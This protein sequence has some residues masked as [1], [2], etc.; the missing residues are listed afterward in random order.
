M[1]NNGGW[2]YT[3]QGRAYYV[4]SKG[5]YL[6]VDEM[7]SSP[8]M[9]PILP[10]INPAVTGQNHQP[11][12]QGPCSWPGAAVPGYAHQKASSFIAPHFGN[13]SQQSS[14]AYVDHPAEDHDAFRD[15]KAEWG[16]AGPPD[17]EYEEEYRQYKS[18]EPEANKA[19]DAYTT[20]RREAS[21]YTGQEVEDNSDT[22]G[23]TPLGTQEFHR[24]AAVLAYNAAQECQRIAHLRSE[25]NKDYIGYHQP[26]YLDGHRQASENYERRASTF[27]ML[28]NAHGNFQSLASHI[29]QGKAR[30]ALR[31]VLKD[32]GN[33]PLLPG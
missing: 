29:A 17:S 13:G 32:A 24:E 31:A 18:A 4:D 5:H 25:Y 2:R 30:K 20:Y 1:D 33:G 8:D 6:Y 21:R 15:A 10:N 12:D 23:G 19:A 11:Y 22:L 16:R 9:S 27:C 7:P 3:A 26:H 14:F 28:A